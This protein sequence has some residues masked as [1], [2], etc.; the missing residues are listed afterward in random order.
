MLEWF[1]IL[2][3]EFPAIRQSPYSFGISI[4]AL[5]ALV[6][7][8]FEWRFKKKIAALE[9]RTPS[10]APKVEALAATAGVSGQGNFSPK[11]EVNIGGSPTTSP[12]ARIDPPTVREQ[13]PRYNFD[14]SGVYVKYLSE[15]T[16]G[17]RIVDSPAY[18]RRGF[19]TPKPAFLI[20]ITNQPH[21]DFEVS[22]VG[23]VTA[24]LTIFSEEEK[25][26]VSPLVW[27]NPDR[28]AYVNFA[29][30]Q[31]EELVIAIGDEFS[32]TW[33]I[34]RKILRHHDSGFRYIDTSYG[35]GQGF[36]P[37]MTL[38]LSTA[39]RVIYEIPLECRWNPD[40]FA[41]QAIRK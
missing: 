11:I 34:P 35:I 22:F 32:K 8:F 13:Q 21:A 7:A 14:H 3:R 41:L 29:I 33:V 5:S 18:S 25:L 6:Y 20:E 27:M 19:F 26:T 31:P 36:T 9:E 10:P 24:S 15:D 1:E 4:L 17:Y 28:F 12:P 38:S 16:D 37:P 39:G 23:D 2:H 40:G 30:G